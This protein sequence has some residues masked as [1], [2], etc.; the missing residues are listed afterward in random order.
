MR[1]LRPSDAVSELDDD[2][3]EVA[4]VV[5][6]HVRRLKNRTLLCN[7]AILSKIVVIYIVEPI[8]TRSGFGASIQPRNHPME[9]RLNFY[10][11]NPEAMKALGALATLVQRVF[12]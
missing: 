10:K 1:V 8:P 5:Q 4:Q 9:P 11:T 6:I 2:Q 3:R 12:R 7:F